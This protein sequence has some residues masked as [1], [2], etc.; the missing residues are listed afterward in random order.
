MMQALGPT[1]RVSAW[2]SCGVLGAQNA[3]VGQFPGCAASAGKPSPVQGYDLGPGAGPIRIQKPRLA[4]GQVQR[5]RVAGAADYR[6]P[7]SESGP[8]LVLRW[9]TDRSCARRLATLCGNF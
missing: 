9:Y 1:L 4:R 7:A 2:K 5:R 6:L 3:M 8:Q